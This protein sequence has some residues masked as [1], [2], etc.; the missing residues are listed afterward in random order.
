MRG[1]AAEVAPHAGASPA[2]VGPGASARGSKRGR[3]DDDAAGAADGGTP[4]LGSGWDAASERASAAKRRRPAERRVVA[5]L[6]Q[7][8]GL[9]MTPEAP[10][11]PAATPFSTNAARRILMALETMT[12]VWLR[13]L[14]FAQ[15][16]LCRAHLRELALGEQLCASFTLLT[17]PQSSLQTPPQRSAPESAVL[18]PPTLSLGP[19]AEAASSAPPAQSGVVPMS[20]AFP[21]YCLPM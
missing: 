15:W 21:T 3:P 10:S 1:G 8:R 14:S 13:G 6:L 18:P 17:A 5:S 2:A 16:R 4:L 7:P 11:D 19:P 20:P 12:Q 9:P